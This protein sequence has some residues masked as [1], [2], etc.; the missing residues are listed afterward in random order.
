MGGGWRTYV[1]VSKPLGELAMGNVWCWKQELKCRLPCAVIILMTAALAQCSVD[2]PA[3]PLCTWLLRPSLF[4]KLQW[5]LPCS[6]ATKFMSIEVLCP[7][8][9]SKSQ[10]TLPYSDTNGMTIM[11]PEPLST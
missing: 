10:C 11:C 4:S 8:G 5:G 9:L 6:S 3:P 2:Y 7:W 1:V